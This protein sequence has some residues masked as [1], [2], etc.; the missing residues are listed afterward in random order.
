[1]KKFCKNLVVLSLLVNFL[2]N[3][4]WGFDRTSACEQLIDLKI[5]KYREHERLYNL[6]ME[7]SDTLDEYLKT[8]LKNLPQDFSRYLPFSNS[9]IL[10]MIKYNDSISG[11]ND[12]RLQDQLWDALN[13]KVYTSRDIRND[14]FFDSPT[15]RM[16]IL[17][18]IK[19]DKNFDRNL[20][21]SRA[22]ATTLLRFNT[23]YYPFGDEFYNFKTEGFLDK[24]I[25]SAVLNIVKSR[26]PEEVVLEYHFS[27]KINK[28]NIYEV[29]LRKELHINGKL[30]HDPEHILNEETKQMSGE[31]LADW[32]ARLREE[33]IAQPAVVKP[34]DKGSIK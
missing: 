13:E 16:D 25:Y 5:R 10:E 34:T 18:R 30:I 24:E 31:C 23:I 28:D 26:K 15:Q 14:N 7:K 2:P 1:M 8:Q 32:H 21:T 12:K 20:S 3:P 19:T 27:G 17:S 9:D 33:G 22:S 6:H 4:S 11:L 29:K